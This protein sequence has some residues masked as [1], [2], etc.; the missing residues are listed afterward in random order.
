MVARFVGEKTKEGLR[1]TASSTTNQVA[2][3]RLAVKEAQTLRLQAHTCSRAHQ[4][5]EGQHAETQDFSVP[6]FQH[7]HIAQC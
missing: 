1:L 2:H 7:R 5:Q 3:L 4:V 6:C